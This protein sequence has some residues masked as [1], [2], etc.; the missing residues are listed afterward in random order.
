VRPELEQSKHD[1]EGKE[2]GKE[3]KGKGKGK[4]K[5][6][7]MANSIDEPKGVLKSPTAM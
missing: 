4:G 3:D 2:K 5:G 1:Q 6:K 7:A